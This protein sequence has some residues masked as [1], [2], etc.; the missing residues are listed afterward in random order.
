MGELGLLGVPW[1]EEL[2][3]AGMDQLS[4]YVTIHEMAKVDAS[5]ALTISAHTN[6]GTSP[7]V[8]FGTEAQRR[9]VRAPARVGPGA[10]RLR[11][12]RAGRR[13]RCR[14]HRH[15]PRWTRATTTSSTAPRSSSPTPAWARSSRSPRAPSRGTATGGSPASSSPRTRSTSTS[16]EARGGTCPDL[17]KTK[18][19]PR[20]QEAGQD[21]LARQRHPRAD[22]RGRRGAQGE[23]AG[24]AGLRLHQLSQDAR[25]RP[26]RHRRS[27]AGDRGRRLR[28]GAALRRRA[29]AVRP[30]DRELPGR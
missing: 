29:Q 23:R 22:L 26:D 2:G 3:G 18:R 11:P 1:S 9:A 12:H 19:R 30:A 10:G 17:P 4:Y 14:R 6:L 13:E 24:Q 27:L 20:G 7:I 5:H 8:E 25:C 16:A 15:R 28:G 21:G